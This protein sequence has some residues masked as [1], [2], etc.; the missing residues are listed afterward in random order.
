MDNFKN[1]M[2]QEW[3][4]IGFSVF[5]ETIWSSSMKQ[6]DLPKIR[7]FLEQNDIK[8]VDV[9]IVIP[10]NNDTPRMRWSKHYE[11]SGQCVSSIREEFIP[12]NSNNLKLTF[13]YR[14]KQEEKEN[15]ETTQK[16]EKE[17]E[18]EEKETTLPLFTGPEKLDPQP[19]GAGR[20][21]RF[22]HYRPHLAR[23]GHRCRRPGWKIPPAARRRTGGVQHLRIASRQ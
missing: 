21:G 5:K 19:P 22:G 23:R 4:Q 10:Q 15:E 11:R 18:Q 13:C 2:I 16:V 12:E 1:T 9:S 17:E 6:M 8:N 7:C 20:I 14:S 3:S